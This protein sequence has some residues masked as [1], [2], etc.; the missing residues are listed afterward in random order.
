[1]LRNKA[2]DLFCFFLFV[3]MHYAWVRIKLHTQ[4]RCWGSCHIVSVDITYLNLKVLRCTTTKE[5]KRT[6]CAQI[7]MQL[8]QTNDVST[9]ADNLNLVKPERRQLIFLCNLSLVVC[10]GELIKYLMLRLFS[11]SA[12]LC[13]NGEHASVCW[14]GVYTYVYTQHMRVHAKVYIVCMCAFARVV[15]RCVWYVHAVVCVCKC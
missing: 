12:C 4:V 3:C 11:D 1:M 15:C 7:R 9:V 2:L 5:K 13:V 6:C 14:Y 8:S 10:V